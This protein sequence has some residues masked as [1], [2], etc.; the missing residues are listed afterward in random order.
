MIVHG[1]P[2]V[3]IIVDSLLWAVGFSSGRDRYCV[4]VQL[5][6]IYWMSPG[7]IWDNILPL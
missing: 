7:E 3:L 5:E 6:G 4:S 1:F 2:C